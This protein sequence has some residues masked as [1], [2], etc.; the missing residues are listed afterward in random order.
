MEENHVKDIKSLQAPKHKVN[1]TMQLS[2][3]K[4]RIGKKREI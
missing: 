1:L 4:E 3:L 2:S